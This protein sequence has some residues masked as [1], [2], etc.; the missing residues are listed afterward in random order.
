MDE[1]IRI[2]REQEQ[3]VPN[4]VRYSRLTTWSLIKS[5]PLSMPFVFVQ[6]HQFIRYWLNISNYPGRL[7]SL[8]SRENNS[9]YVWDYL[10]L[11][12][13]RVQR[14]VGSSTWD[15]TLLVLCWPAASVLR[16]CLFEATENAG[17]DIA[18]R[19]KLQRWKMQELTSRIWRKAEPILHSDTALNYFLNIL[20]S[21]N[22][23][24]SY[25]ITHSHGSAREFKGDEASQWKRPKFDPSPRPNP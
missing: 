24:W 8:I 17:V 2:V 15:L 7:A 13:I 19:T 21:V 14:N 23:E 9:S 18:T 3:S 25:C 16:F 4:T 11:L 20:F 22:K 5:Y 10:S 12:L 6:L 1:F